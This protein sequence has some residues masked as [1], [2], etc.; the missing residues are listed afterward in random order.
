[1]LI[2][3][4]TYKKPLDEVE[5]H[6]QEHRDFLTKYYGKD[7]FIASGPK[8]PRNGGIILA[9]ATREE[10]ETLIKED[11]FYINGIADYSIIVFEPNRYHQDFKTIFS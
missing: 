6:L 7:I 11:P 3:E 10:G 2:I 4:L 5:N 1:M 9:K 8:Q